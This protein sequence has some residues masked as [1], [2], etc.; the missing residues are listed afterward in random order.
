MADPMETPISWYWVLV[1]FLGHSV[2]YR[3]SILLPCGTPDSNI[4]G[5]PCLGLFFSL[6]MVVTGCSFSYSPTTWL[7]DPPLFYSPSTPGEK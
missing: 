1:S 4:S 7:S 5:K 3:A 2:S 6:G